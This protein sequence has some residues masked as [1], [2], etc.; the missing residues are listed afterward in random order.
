GRRA[1]PARCHAPLWIRR[2]APEQAVEQAA[3]R[4]FRLGSVWLRGLSG[5][6]PG[7]GLLPPQ[8]PSAPPL[9]P[10]PGAGPGGSPRPPALGPPAPRPRRR[11][12]AASPPPRCASSP[13]P[14]RVPPRDPPSSRGPRRLVLRPRLQT[15][16]PADLGRRRLPR[17]PHSRERGRQQ[18]RGIPGIAG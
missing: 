17:R 3:L 1:S 11:R 10:P 6:G 13:T 8:P 7:Q 2:S 9:P 12:P 4:R 15:A 18:V 14:L 5:W 16:D